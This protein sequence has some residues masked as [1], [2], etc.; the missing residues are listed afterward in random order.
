MSIITA[1]PIWLILICIAI[2]SFTTW[3]L[4]FYRVNYEMR[5]QVRAVLA[6]LRFLFVFLLSLLLLSPLVLLNVKDVEKPL[7][8]FAQDNSKSILYASD[9]AFYRSD[10]L[11]KIRKLSDKFRDK[12]DFRFF[13]FDQKVNKSDSVYF[14]GDE[15]NIYAL[16]EELKSTFAGR[17]VGALVLASDGIY[18]KG[19]VPT[20]IA[21]VLPFPVYSIMMGDTA[22]KTD[23]SIR[24]V[25]YNRTTFYKN[26]FPVEVQVSAYNLTARNTVL[27][28][29]SKNQELFS[30]N[31]SI[32]NKKHFETVR[33]YI[34]ANEKGLQ[35]YHISIK[36][37][38]GEFTTKNNEYDIFVNVRDARDK[39]LITYQ[40]VNPDIAAIKQALLATDMYQV[41]V[42][43]VQ[44]ID[45]PLNEY[46]AIFA[47]QLPDV[48]NSA[49]NLFSN[50]KQW[51]VPIVYVLGTQSSFPMFNQ[52][53]AG[54]QIGQKNNM[55]NDVF[56]SVNPNFVL[57][58]QA[59]EFKQYLD[60]LP[61]LEAPFGSYT[62][63][64]SASVFLYQRIGNF[65]S[66][67]PLVLFNDQLGLKNCIIAGEGIWKWRLACY[68]H[69]QH[70]RFFDDL[71]NKIPQYLVAQ[72]DNSNFRVKINQ[73][74][75]QNEPIEATAELYNLSLEL[76]NSPEVSFV[77]TNSQGKEFP[78]SFSRE[79]RSYSINVGLFPQGEYRWVAKT[80]LGDKEYQ[81]SG[82][83][84]VQDVNLE[85][86][87]LMADFSLMR[88]LATLHGGKIISA[89]NVEDVAT[90]IEKN[91]NIKPI[92]F[93]TKSYN[94]LSNSWLYW[95]L[96]VLLA[97][98]EWFIRKFNGLF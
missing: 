76:D 40:T 93:F 50:A 31:I 6:I 15:T 88:S 58:S 55:W 73:F 98:F 70:Y 56:P 2:A 95:A 96:L 11:Q 60:E 43:Q 34:D 10:Y 59:P 91:P 41:D 67:M 47:Y 94:D 80:K 52:L 32:S 77:V 38:D 20:S 29:S 28:V 30:K 45:K 90:E 68:Q 53:N 83:F 12:Y 26:T 17:N 84:I 81:K 66:T 62:I 65:I 78:F 49:A 16:F 22:Q 42:K 75:T 3:F 33:L 48:E 92:S 19:G 9:S 57:F 54:V 85:S 25:D 5:K 51:S 71:I 89:R 97:V 79:N 87:N 86:L 8:V 74:F 37:I 1:Y 13:T 35:K 4:Y 44:E 24:S 18:N 64:N 21:E 27:T 14:N 39:I 72:S 7:L 61:P 82:A 69:Y 23:L 63:S 36:P 46:R